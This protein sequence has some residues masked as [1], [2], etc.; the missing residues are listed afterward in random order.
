LGLKRQTK[1][2]AKKQKKTALKF[3]SIQ[4]C[5]KQKQQKKWRELLAKQPKYLYRGTPN[6]FRRNGVWHQCR[7]SVNGWISACEALVAVDI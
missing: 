2:A 7:W 6:Q 5:G 4:A 3:S 1:I